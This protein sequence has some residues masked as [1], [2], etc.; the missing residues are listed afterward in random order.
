MAKKIILAVLAVVLLCGCGLG[1][2]LYLWRTDMQQHGELSV[3]LTVE[4]LQDQALLPGKTYPLVFRVQNS[5]YSYAK[6][7]EYLVLSV[8]DADGS[9][10]TVDSMNSTVCDISLK[11]QEDLTF[12]VQDHQIV[13]FLGEYPIA[14][15]QPKFHNPFVE[16]EPAPTGFEYAESEHQT[17]L[18]LVTAQEMASRYSNA[19]IRAEAYIQVETEKGWQ[20]LCQ[21]CAILGAFGTNILEPELKGVPDLTATASLAWEFHGDEV[22]VTGIGTTLEDHIVIP[23][24]VCLKQTEKGV[25]RTFASEVLWKKYFTRYGKA[26]GLERTDGTMIASRE[27]LLEHNAEISKLH[28]YNKNTFLAM[29]RGKEF[30]A[31]CMELL[32]GT[33]LEIANYSSLVPDDCTNEDP[34][35]VLLKD[36]GGRLVEDPFQ[37]TPYP[38]I[39]AGNAFANCDQIRSVTFDEGVQVLRNSMY[40]RE[41][42]MFSGCDNLKWVSGIPSGVRDMEDTFSDCISLSEAPVLPDSLTSMGDTF[43]NCVSLEKGPAIPDSVATMSMTFNGCTALKEAQ[44]GKNVHNIQG[45]F[46]GC[47]ALVQAPEIGE[48]VVNMSGCFYECT[49]LEEVNVGEN[50]TDLT[51]CFFGC[52]AL[53]NAPEIPETVEQMNYA[54]SGCEALCGTVFLP[55]T[56]GV[57][58][59]LQYLDD[60]YAGCENLEKVEVTYCAEALGRIEVTDELNVELVGEHREEGVCPDCHTV[61]TETEIDELKVV[62]DLVPEKDYEELLVYIDEQVPALLKETCKKLTVTDDLGKYDQ[63]FTDETYTGFATFPQGVAYV[64]TDSTW[65]HYTLFHELAHCFDFDYSLYPRYSTSSKWKQLHKAE[66]HIALMYYNNE[67]YLDFDLSTKRQESFAVSVGVYYTEP[68]VLKRECPGIYAYLEELLNP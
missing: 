52:T 42:G 51:S 12:G 55:Y 28:I 60:V 11:E 61:T 45:C 6:L 33:A 43:T 32:D 44:I 62:F 15:A 2:Y 22:W 58:N 40:H 8:F 21:G 4:P 5:G 16:D 30:P 34:F 38:V 68:D 47:T 36:P 7:R 54:F 24:Q 56:A 10:I 63:D 66:E 57:R 39:V 18:S 1:V 26:Y 67:T 59:I 3:E 29:L 17:D 35:V 20:P 37:G 41:Q 50:V 48:N 19:V 64:K 53:E 25:F 27:E 14:S 23:A 31:V 9:P 46:Q 49:A 65:L 13:Y